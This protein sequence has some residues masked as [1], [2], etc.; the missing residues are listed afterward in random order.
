MPDLK[1]CPFCGGTQQH[2][3]TYGRLWFD[4]GVLY[5]VVCLCGARSYQSITE[6][7]AIEAWNRRVGEEDK[8]E[9]VER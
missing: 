5:A 3:E 9:L 2:I 6:E 7:K 8:H 1:P 4:Y